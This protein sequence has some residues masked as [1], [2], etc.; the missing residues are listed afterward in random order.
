M[1]LND[2]TYKILLVEDDENISSSL[3]TALEARNYK[4]DVFSDGLKAIRHLE[5]ATADSADLVLLDLMLPGANGWE[6]LVKIRSLPQTLNWPVIMITCV[7]D[8]SS[9]T[10]AL[11]DGADDYVTKPFTMK[12]LLARIEANLRK[13]DKQS[14]RDFEV[15]F[16]DGQ[17]ESLTPRETELLSYITKGYSNKEIS[18]MLCISEITVTN[19]MSRI[20]QKLKVA[21]RLQAAILAFKYNLV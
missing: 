20:F 8:E 6:I 12:V 14:K 17:F 5:K 1:E 4:V 10:R 9:E 11:Y 7:D 15:H 2:K 19:H 18:Q 13:R 3:K 21:N 16:S